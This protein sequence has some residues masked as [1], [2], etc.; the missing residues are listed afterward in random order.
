MSPTG[1][2][3][4]AATTSR[5]PWATPTRF[6]GHRRLSASKC[7]SAFE[8]GP[9]SGLKQD[10]DRLIRTLV[11]GANPDRRRIGERHRREA[12]DELAEH[13]FEFELRQA[14]PQTK[15]GTSAERSAR[16]SRTADVELLRV[17]EHGGI[18]IC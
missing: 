16:L 8:G 17:I 13:H 4:W 12:P 18:M 1:T 9:S 7:A 11:E 3:S 14:R 2:I 15:M 5:P 10:R 6:P